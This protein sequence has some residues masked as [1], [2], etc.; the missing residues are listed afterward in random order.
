MTCEI[1]GGPLLLLG[2]LGSLAHYNCRDCGMMFS[3][4]K[5]DLGDEDDDEFDES[6]F[7]PDLKLNL[8]DLAEKGE[9]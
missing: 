1:C 5:P 6:E 4:G 8:P 2:V 9:A 7:D 3:G